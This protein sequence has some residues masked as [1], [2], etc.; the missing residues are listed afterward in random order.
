MGG[1]ETSTVTTHEGNTVVLQCNVTANPEAKV[2]WERE[3]VGLP[4]NRTV[5]VPKLGL[6]IDSTQRQDTGTYTCKATNLLGTNTK[7]IILLV[8]SKFSFL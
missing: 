4:V 2:T 8:E 1:S 6:V 7:T 3:G 5:T